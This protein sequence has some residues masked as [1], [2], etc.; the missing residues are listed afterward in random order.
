MYQMCRL[1]INPTGFNTQKSTNRSFTSNPKGGPPA[2]LVGAFTKMASAIPSPKSAWENSKVTASRF[3]LPMAMWCSFCTWVLVKSGKFFWGL[4]SCMAFGGRRAPYIP[5]KVFKTGA[6]HWLTIGIH[7][8]GR[9]WLPWKKPGPKPL[10]GFLWKVT[11]KTADTQPA[12]PIFGCVQPLK[13]K[14][15]PG[16]QCGNGKFTHVLWDV[17]GTKGWSALPMVVFLGAKGDQF[18][19]SYLLVTKAHAQNLGTSFWHIIGTRRSTQFSRSP[20]F[21]LTT[22]LHSAWD[23]TK[24]FGFCIITTWDPPKKSHKFWYSESLVVLLAGRAFARA[25]GQPLKHQD[26]CESRVGAWCEMAWN[27]LRVDGTSVKAFE[28]SWNSSGLFMQKTLSQSW[29]WNLTNKMSTEK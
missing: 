20:A 16:I 23:I 4:I 9:V 13:F 26:R 3:T 7:I 5:M 11:L 17:S 25:M 15:P 2:P 28:N 29:K 22:V 21:F 8:H 18:L 1:H 12:S 19:I 24:S 14:Y 10:A 27:W 6:P